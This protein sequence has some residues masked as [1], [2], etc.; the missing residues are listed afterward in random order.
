MMGRQLLQ[1]V[2][3]ILHQPEIALGE[4]SQIHGLGNNEMAHPR[5][6]EPRDVIAPI[7]MRASD[8]EEKRAFSLLQLPGIEQQMA[9]LS[10]ITGLHARGK[11]GIQFSGNV[12]VVHGGAA[13][14][15]QSVRGGATSFR[16]SD[17]LTF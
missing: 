9:D 1:G 12:G 14:R 10:G 7:V 3:R 13:L 11:D 17:V 6:I 4:S 16:R 15:L 2:H 8:G 5:P